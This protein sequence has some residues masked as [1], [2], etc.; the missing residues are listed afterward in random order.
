MYYMGY[1]HLFYQYNPDGPLWG[2]INWGHAVSRDLVHWHHIKHS[3]LAPG[4]D[5]YD[6]NGV[7]SGS[8]TILPDGTPALLYTGWSNVSQVYQIQTQNLALPLNTSDPLLRDWIK[9]PSNPI[10]IP[11]KDFEGINFRDPTEGWVGADGDWRVLVGGR[12]LK[13]NAG[14]AHLYTSRSFMNWT[15]SHELHSVAGTGMWECP[16]FYPVSLEGTDGLEASANSQAMKHILKMSAN[17]HDYYVVGTYDRVLDTFNP[18]DPQLDLGLGVRYD[19][20]KFYASK[21]FF[22]EATDRRILFGWINESDSQQDDVTKGWSGLQSLPRKIWLDPDT[23]ENLIQ[24]PV[25][26][27]DTL[28]KDSVHMVNFTLSAGSVMP[29]EG[30][31][32]PQ[33][34]IQVE[35]SKPNMPMNLLFNGTDTNSVMGQ[36]ICATNGTSH[37]GLLG[38]FGVL[39]LAEKNLRELTGV[40]FYITLDSDGTWKA[41]LCSDQSRSSM[42]D[43]VDRT[44]YGT[45]VQV[46]EKDQSL[47][48]RTLVDH[49]IV[50]SFAQGGR[51]VITARV[52]PT[53]ALYND[54]YFYLFNNGTQDIEVLSFNA[55]TMDD[56]P[57]DDLE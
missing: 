7:W 30:V 18:D 50:E 24:E 35:F 19:Y 42:Q 16:D 53:M 41:L 36:E 5:W 55:W 39:V 54:A 34:D 1:Y 4:P 33:L 17:S 10:M 38:P 26:E 28:H 25:E 48:L 43:D 15:Y 40:F 12:V 6:I 27:I 51:T 47:R 20:G 22:D 56:A 3:A 46:L 31:H 14:T 52:Y 9:S 13:N 2:D 21:T 45:Y 11:E 49:S 37:R 32:G 29:I 23:G 57:L 44:T 8:S